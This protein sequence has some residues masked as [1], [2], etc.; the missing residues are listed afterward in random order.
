M[1]RNTRFGELLKGLS[2]GSFE[3][4]VDKYQADKFSKGFRCWDQLVAMIYGQV[5]GCRSLRELEAGFNS[6]AIDHYHLGTRHIK[7]STLSDANAKK[8]VRVYED[9]CRQLMNRVHRAQRREL[10]E[11]LYLLDST[12]IQLK[13]TGFDSWTS[14]NKTHRTQGLKAH[15]M[16]SSEASLPVYLDITAPNVN[17][18]IAGREIALESGATYVFDKGYYDYNWWYQFTKQGANFVTRFKSNAGLKVD[19]ALEIN[20][21]DNEIIL[22]DEIV[23]FKN[24]HPGGQ[25][26]N[27]HYGTP[28]RRITVSREN[29]SPLVLATNDLKRS[30]RELAELYKKRWDIELFF[31]WLK[32]NLK[33]KQFL[34]RNE[35][36]V[37]V[38]I[39]IAIIAYLLVYIYRKVNGFNTSLR[40]CVAT[41]KTGMFQRPEIESE[42]V[43]K[44]RWRVNQCRA[45]QGSL[46]L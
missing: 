32:Q 31:K 35:N 43:R 30:A 11:M 46:A 36:A 25:R 20:E 15:V 4:V 1:Y 22:R 14:D 12:P 26:V 39:Y 27:R 7:R 18:V 5:A 38:Q 42:L 37:R 28:L 19:K 24:K 23:T 40:L 44:R 41:L 3:K 16:I 2:R 10:S 45:L 34:G 13:G 29:K 17:D 8:D 21:Q 9:V 6:Q 33:I